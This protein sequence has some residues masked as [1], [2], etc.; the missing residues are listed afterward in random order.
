MLPSY[1]PQGF[2]GACVLVSSAPEQVESLSFWETES[3]LDLN[4][5]THR[6]MKAMK[7]VIPFIAKQP[8]VE[9]MDL[10]AASFIKT[11]FGEGD[12]QK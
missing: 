1:N 9:I 11:E 5:N 4:N 6:Y 12:L 2:L 10:P 3:D 8:K 7:T